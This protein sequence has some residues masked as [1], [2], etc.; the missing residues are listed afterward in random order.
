MNPFPEILQAPSGTM[1]PIA[2]YD[3]TYENDQRTRVFYGDGGPYLRVPGLLNLERVR[4]GSID[5]PRERIDM[6]LMDATGKN[7][8]PMRI[9]LWD[10]S[11]AADGV[12]VLRRGIASNNGLWQ[13]GVA[14]FL[15]GDW[16][17]SV[18]LPDPPAPLERLPAGSPAGG[19]HGV[20]RGKSRA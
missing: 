3:R 17:E 18:P 13:E 6:V 12:P 7:L 11:P 9:P 20:P 10:V 19:R 8:A 5:V 14:V 2:G 4:I 15:T 1:H 16:D